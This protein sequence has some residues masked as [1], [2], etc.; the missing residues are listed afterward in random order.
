VFNW[1]FVVTNVCAFTEVK[2]IANKKVKYFF[3]E[4]NIIITKL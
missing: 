1:V 4:S 3:C 2:N